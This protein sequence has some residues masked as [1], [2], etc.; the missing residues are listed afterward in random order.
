MALEICVFSPES[1]DD[2]LVNVLNVIKAA[3]TRY[4]VL[5]DGLGQGNMAAAIR[6][7]TSTAHLLP[8]SSVAVWSMA[9]ANLLQRDMKADSWKLF[10]DADF[11][12]AQKLPMPKFIEMARQHDFLSATGRFDTASK[13][14]SFPTWECCS[15]S[16]ALW[17]AEDFRTF[18]GNI[19]NGMNAEGRLYAER[20]FYEH[21]RK[22]FDCTSLLSKE[23]SS[24]FDPVGAGKILLGRWMEKAGVA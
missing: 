8:W 10:V 15:I 14:F 3:D 7:T 20:Y 21:F 12:A 5:S 24:Q 2:N 6:G 1:N 17:Q 13:E 19:Q 22:S 11:A 9:V 4:L 23:T 18:L 16:P